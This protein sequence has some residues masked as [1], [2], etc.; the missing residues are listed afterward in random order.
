M[1]YIELSYMNECYGGV[2]SPLQLF[3]CH[4]AKYEFL[5]F[6]YIGY[7]KAYELKFLVGTFFLISLAP[8]KVV[9]PP[10]TKTIHK[11][12]MRN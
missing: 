2:K 1:Y 10:E 5:A 11:I 8:T 9:I 12:Y 6:R 7:K 3:V 4:Y